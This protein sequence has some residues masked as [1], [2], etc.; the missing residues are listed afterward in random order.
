MEWLFFRIQKKNVISLYLFLGTYLFIFLVLYC[1][2]SLWFIW[3]FGFRDNCYNNLSLQILW[4]QDLQGA[5][6]MIFYRNEIELLTELICSDHYTQTSMT[7]LHLPHTKICLKHGGY[8][9]PP[10][11]IWISMPFRYLCVFWALMLYF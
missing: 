2:F 11:S 5:K 1:L 4:Q 3:N 7:F 8:K 10:M 9:I 6:S